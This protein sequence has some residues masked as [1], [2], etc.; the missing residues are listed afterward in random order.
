MEGAPLGAAR[1]GAVPLHCGLLEH[2]DWDSVE[3]ACNADVEGLYLPAPFILADIVAH[4]APDHHVLLCSIDQRPD[5][6]E[7]V[8]STIVALDEA[9]ALA[10]HV[11]PQ[12]PRGCHRHADAAAPRRTRQR[13]ARFTPQPR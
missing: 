4:L 2:A 7:N 3:S 5:M 11:F 9:V 13:A 1:L 8:A 6:D 12:N 10:I